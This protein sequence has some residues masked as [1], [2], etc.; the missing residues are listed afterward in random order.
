MYSNGSYVNRHITVFIKALC[1][2]YEQL[3]YCKTYDCFLLQLC[4]QSPAKLKK[5]VCSQYKSLKATYVQSEFC[6]NL[7][8]EC[9]YSKIYKH[10][11]DTHTYQLIK[12]Y[13]YIL[14]YGIKTY[15][16]HLYIIPWLSICTSYMKLNFL[17]CING[18]TV[19]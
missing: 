18:L 17:H 1:I 7:A 14:L 5:T 6:Y 19:L 2:S 9:E 15:G 13:S 8:Q 12:H 4:L 11:S 3:L 10:L 16:I